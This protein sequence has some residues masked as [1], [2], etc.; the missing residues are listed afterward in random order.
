MS[1]GATIGPL[2]PGGTLGVQAIAALGGGPPIL[3]AASGAINPHVSGNYFIT[4][5]GVAA[6]TLAAPTAG[7]DDGVLLL[8]CSTT[9]NAHTITTPAAGD[10]QDGNTS[11]HNT[12]LT[13]NAH[14]GANCTLRAYNG[15]WYVTDE[16]GCSLTS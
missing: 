3:L 7:S 4:K 1:T 16:V 11:G 15:T 10:I 9:A 8:I 13:M 5:A 14:I 6:M 12:V 2:V